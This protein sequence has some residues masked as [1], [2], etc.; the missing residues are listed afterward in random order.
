MVGRVGVVPLAASAFVNAVAHLPLVF[1]LGLLSSV[2]VLSAQAFGARENREAGEVLRHGLALGAV[3]GLASAASLLCL[4]PVLHLFGQ[5]PEVISE[6]RAYLTLFGLSMF[7]ILVAVVCKQFCE[8]L[9]H[10]WAPMFIMLGGVLL[11][12]LLNWVLIFGHW[13][14]PAMGLEGAGWATLIARCA[15]G[16]ALLVYL[17]VAE[18]LRSF[19]PV[20][21]LASLAWPRVSR[22]LHLGWPVAAQHLMEVSA[23][24]FAAIM[25]GWISADAIAAHQ[26]AIT[27]AATSFMLA[28]GTGM[29]ACIRVGQAW[30]AGQYRRMRRIGFIGV[31]LASAMMAC[32]AV[33][34]VTA[35]PALARLFTSS[36]AVIALTVNLLILAAIFQLADAAQVSAICALRGLADVRV[37][38]IIAVLAYWAVAVPICYVL[39]FWTNLGAIGIWTGLTVGL[40]V[41]AVSLVWRFH[42]KTAGL[43]N[44]ERGM[45]N[46]ECKMQNAE[47]E[48]VTSAAQPQP[49]SQTG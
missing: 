27:C 48:V 36:P 21:W 1:A 33:L 28:L 15:I 13:G 41:A 5:P 17:M 14:S 11:N 37:P 35:G 3:A 25:M 18:S 46:A 39:G 6:C 38:A 43:K 8:A 9:N 34:F 24:V 16:L 30:G 32:F 2:G 7:P 22:L 10:P 44:A 49:S 12:I 23:F 19:L 26:I 31:V 45:Q 40:I 20:A 42:R 47:T 4:H 29:A